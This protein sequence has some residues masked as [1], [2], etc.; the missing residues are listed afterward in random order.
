MQSVSAPDLRVLAG[1]VTPST[2]SPGGTLDARWT[3]TNG[4]TGT[5]N[6]STTVLRVNQSATTAA[7]TNVRSLPVGGLS[8]NTSID[9][10]AALIAPATP[11]TY[12]VWAWADNGATAGQ[13][14]TAAADDIVALGSFMVQ[15][16]AAVP[17]PATPGG[18]SPGALTGPGPTQASNNVTLSWSASSG[19]TSYSFGVTDMATLALVVDQT[20]YAGTSYTANLVA[21][22]QYRWNVAACNSTGCSLYTSRLYFQTPSAVVTSPTTPANP[23]PGSASSPGP[24]LA[25]RTVTLSWSASSG[26]TYYNFGV[27]DMATLGLVVDINN[28]GGTSYTTTLVAG[29]Q[30]R[31]NVSA[32][33]SAGCSSYTTRMYFRTP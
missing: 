1:K 17:I 8:A 26:A 18:T 4:G 19:A 22:K 2:I 25:S 28:Y 20:N 32:C 9:Q 13:S 30:Y 27:T 12:W 23:T 6:P 29:K 24:T 3:V 5:A 10:S 31:W 21:G 15:S 14:V 33:N 11:G 7:G 16:V